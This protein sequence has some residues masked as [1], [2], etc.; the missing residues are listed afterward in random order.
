MVVLGGGQF[1]VSE[2]PLYPLRGHRCPFPPDYELP[3]YPCTSSRPLSSCHSSCPRRQVNRFVHLFSSSSPDR[4]RLNSTRSASSWMLDRGQ[5]LVER[6]HVEERQP[7]RASLLLIIPRP[8]PSQLNSQR[9]L[10]D[11]RSGPEAGGARPCRGASTASCIS[12]PHHPQ[13]GTVSTQLAALPHGV[14]MGT[15]L[16]ALPPGCSM[17]ASSWRSATTSRSVTRG[18]AATCQSAPC[19]RVDIPQSLKWRTGEYS[20]ELTLGRS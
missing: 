9:F 11:A 6:D 1:L 2:V 17:G 15:Q 4:N 7:L 13:T 18:H 16:A 8:E 3:L 12:S 20:P 14:S 10:L 19:Q 5:K